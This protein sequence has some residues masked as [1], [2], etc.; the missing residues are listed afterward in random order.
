MWRIGDLE[1]DGGVVLGPMSGFTFAS[2]RDFMKPFGVAVS[3][4]EMVSGM[5]LVY[6][7][8]RTARYLEFGQERP[9]GIQLF[10]SKPDAMA[11]AAVKAL[12]ARPT[13]D[14]F[15]FNMGCPVPKVIRNGAGSALMKDPAACGRIIRSM[16]SAVDVPITVKMRLGWDSESI[17]FKEIIDEVVS[18]GA[19][20]VTIH[21]RTK[22]E[23]YTGTPHY[24]LIEG[25]QSEI[26]VPLIV[27]GNIYSLDDAIN[28]MNITGATAVM[29]ARGGIGNPF[30]VTQIDRYL[31]TGEALPNPTVSQ[32]VEWCLQLMDMVLEE[33]GEVMGM[34]KLRSI[35]PKFVAGCWNCREYRRDIARHASDKESMVRILMQAE[36]EMG[37]KR[38]YSYGKPAP[39]C[40]FDCE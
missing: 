8:D 16:K 38:I 25:L 9:M 2:Y 17:N 37:D 12:E 6:G 20:A 7:Q 18:A 14:F 40:D 11:E 23:R 30:L 15:D 32:Q 19:D 3:V 36:A 31:R 10:G 1:I 24:D 26:P 33:K 22:E 35:V 34:S 27:S 13:I 4:S 5:G 21:A 28:A 39:D 29:V